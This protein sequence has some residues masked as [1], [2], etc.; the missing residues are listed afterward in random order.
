MGFF[1]WKTSDTQETIWNIYSGKKT[2]GVYLIDDRGNK[3]FEDK[4]DGYGFFGGKDFY[5]LLAE[6]NGK[7]SD[8]NIGLDLAFSDNPSEYKFPK[9][10]VDPNIK[11]EDVPDCKQCRTQGFFNF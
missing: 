2:I 4:Y 3:W 11:Y 9:L 8:R 5:E 6:M 1:S 10:V 7:E